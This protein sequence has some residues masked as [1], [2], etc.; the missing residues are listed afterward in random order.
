MLAQMLTQVSVGGNDALEPEAVDP[1]GNGQLGPAGGLGMGRQEG[2]D[3][4]EHGGAL[5]IG[6]DRHVADG[7][8]PLDHRLGRDGL[9]LAELC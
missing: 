2:P 3:L 7:R 9:R 6:K 1:V 5:G 8:H 4:V